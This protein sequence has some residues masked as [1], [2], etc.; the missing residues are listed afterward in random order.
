[1]ARLRRLARALPL[2]RRAVLRWRHRRALETLAARAPVGVGPKVLVINHHF[3]QDIEALSATLSQRMQFLVVD[4]MPFFNEAVL[5]FRT[6]EA[7]DGVI[8]YDQLPPDV[9]LSYREACR[10]MFAELQRVFPFELV[11][12]PSDSF[13][14]IREFLAVAGESGVTRVVLDKEGT[15]SPYSFEVHSAQIKAKFPFMSDYLLVWSARQREFWIRAGAPTDRIRVVGQPRSDFFFQK[16]RWH[17]RRDLGLDP[18]R[19]TVVFF[20]FDLDAYINVFPAE[21]IA[22][23]SLSWLPLRN[24]VSEVL[25]AFA[26]E[27][28]DVDIVVK[29]HPQQSDVADVRS[30][31]ARSGRPNIKVLDGAGVSNHLI[32]NAD[33]IIGFQTTT[34]TEAMLTTVPVIY[35]A[36]GSTERKVRRHLIPFHDCEGIEKADSRDMLAALLHKWSAGQSLGGDR[37]RRRAFTDYWLHADGRS[38]ER[39][40]DELSCM[41]SEG[42]APESA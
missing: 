17:S 11:V 31:F 4:A 36:W 16:Q 9:V 21:E 33:L 28:P 37:S 25:I 2:A 35:V 10:R 39:V 19:R 1:M 27:Q 22:R 15:I 24:D 42:P 13:W 23:E 41:L 34:L 7:R 14:W 29:V 3:D 30:V 6:P 18:N 26:A 40:G 32:V 5:F 12:V 8:P 20:T 38:C